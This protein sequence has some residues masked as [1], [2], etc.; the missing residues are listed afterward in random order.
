MTGNKV[1]LDTNIIT[2]WLKGNSGIADYIDQAEEVYIPAIVVGEMYYGA[3][4]STQVEKNIQNINRLTNRYKVLNAYASTA[5]AY[6]VIKAA[7][8]RKGKPIPENAM[9]IAAIAR[10][11]LLPLITQR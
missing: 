8:R 11:Y 1:L 7:L 10:Q 9:W 2:E 3:Q 6:G 4:Y 5:A